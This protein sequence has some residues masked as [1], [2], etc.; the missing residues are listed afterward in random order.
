MA[1]KLAFCTEC[2]EDKVH[3]LTIEG[4]DKDITL[5]C[6]VC[7]HFIKV[8]YGTT[9]EGMSEFLAEHKLANDREI[10]RTPILTDEEKEEELAV[11]DD[12]VT[13]EETPVEEET[14]E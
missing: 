12:G 5:T 7:G 11:F 1:T 9:V 2:N 4:T 14:I 6:S 10:D 8:P 3:N 13:P